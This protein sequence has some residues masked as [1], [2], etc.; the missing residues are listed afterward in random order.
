MW[1]VTL[2]ATA[3]P[4][5]SDINLCAKGTLF[6]NV[7]GT[8]DFV[9]TSFLPTVDTGS[10][11]V[12]VLT[13]DKVIH[14]SR[15]DI[16]TKDSIVLSTVGKG[17]FAEV[18]VVVGG[19]GDYAGATGVVTATGTFLSG[20]GEV[21]SADLHAVAATPHAA[22][23]TRPLRTRAGGPFARNEAPLGAPVSRLRAW[24]QFHPVEAPPPIE[25]LR[26]SGHR[27][28]ASSLSIAS[29]KE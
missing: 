24:A 25:P 27:H 17:E 28:P 16:H 9:G 4:C 5:G 26:A 8:S 22:A 12:V 10:T 23:I 11:G 18:D 1:R 7:R 3:G 2:E 15:G 20:V 19:T 14:T 13:G 21:S 6:G 29:V